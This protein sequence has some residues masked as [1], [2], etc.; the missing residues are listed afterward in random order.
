MPERTQFDEARAE[1][2]LHRMERL[3]TGVREISRIDSGAPGE[4]SP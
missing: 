2:V 4:T 3:I 1:Q